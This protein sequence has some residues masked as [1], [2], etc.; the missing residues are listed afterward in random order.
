MVIWEKFEQKVEAVLHLDCMH[1]MEFVMEQINVKLNAMEWDALQTTVHGNGDVNR[2][3]AH[4]PK[5]SI[6]KKYLKWLFY[7]V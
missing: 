7:W 2:I 5:Q 3:P 4:V 6:T 1:Q